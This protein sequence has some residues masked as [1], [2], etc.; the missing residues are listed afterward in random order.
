MR[1]LEK[2]YILH[3]IPEAEQHLGISHL[4]EM[5]RNVSFGVIWLGASLHP[6]TRCTENRVNAVATA[7]LE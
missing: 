6:C 3:A 1:A 4:R 2:G 7:G 5:G